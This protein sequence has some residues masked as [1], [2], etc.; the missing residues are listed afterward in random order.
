MEIIKPLRL[1]VLHR[2]YHW[3][4]G[5]R[6]AVTAIAL[7]TL[8]ESPVLLPE[9]ELWA[10]LDEALDE[11]EQIDLLM[12]KP[13]PEFLVN[14]HAYNVH[15]TDRRRCRVQARLDDRCKALVVHG[16][17][18]WAEGEAGEPADF[19]AMPLGR[20]RAYG[21]P[22]YEANPIGIGH[23]PESVD[24]GECWP[25]PNVE[26][27]GQPPFAPGQPPETPAGFGM[28]DIDAPAHRAKLGQ[29]DEETLERD[30]PGLAESFD[31]RFFNLAPD[32]QQW[33]DRD[34]LA[35]GLEYEFLNLHPEL[36]RL[37]G[38]LP[39]GLARC[40]VM[41]QPAEGESALEEIPL[42]LTTA[43]FFPDRRRVALI[44]H[45]DLAVDDEQAS[46]IQYLMPAFEAGAAPRGLEHYA[47]ALA[48]RL[49]EEEGD[50]YAFDE[51]ALIHEPFIGAGF[52]TEPLDQGPS[53]PLMDNLLRRQEE[54]MRNERERMNSLGL[55]PQRLAGL[56]PAGDDEELRLQRLADLPRVGRNIRRKEAELEAQAERERAAALERL[57]DQEPTTANRELLAQLENPDRELPPFD[58]AAR[59]A[60]LREVYRMDL[61]AASA[62]LP[63][64]EESER[65]LRQQYRDSVH[66][67]GAAPALQGAAAEALR[68]KVAQAYA[69]DRDLAGM[70][71][72]GA[73][74]SGMDLSGARLTGV[75][76]ESANLADARLDG[77]DLREAILARARLD[78]A[79][80]RGADCR[81]ANLSR[82]Q[83]RNAC[84]SGATFGDGQCW[85]ARFE[86]C[87]FSHA[88][89]GGILWQGCELD[90]CRFDGAVLED[91]SLHACRLSRPSFVGASLS[92]VTWVESSLEAAD[93]ERAELDDCS[94]VE[95]RSPDARFVGA[96]LSA[97]YMVLGSSLEAADFGGAR[98]AE[99]NLRGVDLSGARFCGTR[100]ADCDLSEARLAGADLRRATASGCLFSGADLRTARLG[101]A[102]LMQCLL[103]RADL[104]GADLR[105]ASLFG[106]DLAEVHLDED[107]LL[108]ETDF[109]R[110]AFHPRR[111]SEAAS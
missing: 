24:G 23:V 101:D 87:D 77:A 41:R 44:H 90:A 58:F 110:V 13:C 20:R 85:E 12:P 76:L 92:A 9:Q 30:G 17:R 6:L 82:A 32:D 31:W 33:P 93:F 99:S 74:L 7:A 81:G 42:R 29:Y 51:A 86:T 69:R 61:S 50:L 102:H 1:G 36:A 52:D 57:R 34:R 66:C 55:D 88:R 19:E 78:G 45:G 10:L 72:T 4:H 111:R 5:H 3:R 37:A 28:R 56:A 109:G 22:G 98:L 63:S 39:D 15:G 106:S 68:R 73:D 54:A 16:D 79:S 38:H 105:G 100:L 94:L 67:C 75:L 18:Y 47:E 80:L 84:F 107:S 40:F 104:R 11:N 49:D 65:R 27:D 59:S 14:G 53:D 71:L 25:L 103:R 46:D 97:C 60:Q 64:R 62:D 8:E 91:L 26:H 108:D 43:W 83:A 95:T 21:G 48:R 70:D 35:G 89:F 2:T 96:A